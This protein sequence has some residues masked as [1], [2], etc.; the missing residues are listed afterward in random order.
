MKTKKIHSSSIIGQQGINLIEKRVLD[1]G[2]IWYPTGAIEAGIDGIIEIRDP[3][4]GEVYN[5]IIQVQSKAT[6]NP[7]QAETS[8]SFHYLCDEN[9]LDYWLKGNA[10]VILIVSRPSTDEAYWISI[11]HYFKDPTRRKNRKIL[12]NKNKDN[13]DKTCIKKLLKIALPED[14]GIY[15]SPPP[16]SEKLFT[17][18][19]EVESFAPKIYI[20]DTRF[21]SYKSLWKRLNE[22][23]GNFAGEWILKD[24]RIL[25]F[26]NLEEYPWNKI[27]DVGTLEP[28][29]STEWAFSPEIDKRKEFV[30]LLNVALK[31][32]VWP[33]LKFNQNKECFYF[34]ATR[35]L[36]PLK[37]SYR[38]ASGRTA[39]RTIFEVYY[40]KRDNYRIS[41]YRHSAFEGQ[42]ML[43]DGIWYLEITPTYFYTYNGHN[44]DKYYED[45]L[46][47]IKQLERNPALLGQLFMWAHFLGTHDDLFTDKYP[48]LEFV[49]L[50][51]FSIDFGL[52][53]A[54][55]LN[56]EIE[57]EIQVVKSN[58][59][60]LPLFEQ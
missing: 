4:S 1:M 17:N 33:K 47:K 7:F 55:W 29:D 44:L 36:S 34:R 5:S 3:N 10:P 24:K 54:S 48:F 43:F 14:A 45:R 12:F 50:K 40:S 19:L 21:R 51:Q 46:S 31:G 37:I 2:F 53:D 18:L 49:E 27:C 57:E 38:T 9:H 42:F 16:K 20:A 6:L 15:I 56:N 26:N 8:D 59:D 41:Y 39:T 23:G 28:F 22:L 25:S 13:F 60:E 11:K 32:K 30:Q 52:D 58:F 35:N